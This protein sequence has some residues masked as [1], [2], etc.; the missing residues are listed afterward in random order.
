M[1]ILSLRFKNLNSLA[2]E[3][4]LD[5]ENGPLG[6][7]GIFL[8]SGPTGAGKTT[9]LDAI[10]VALYE[11][12]PRLE[13]SGVRNIMTQQKGDCF[14]EV[15][16]NVKDKIYRSRWTLRRAYGKATGNF[17]DSERELSVLEDG[18]FVIL[19]NKKKLI[20][21]KTADITGLNFD[22]FTRSMLLPQGNFAAFLEAKENERAD[23]LEKMTGTTIYSEISQE[24]YKIY[25]EEQQK[26][27]GLKAQLEDI[28]PSTEE[29]LVILR[30]NKKNTEEGIG[31]VTKEISSLQDKA[32]WLKTIEILKIDIERTIKSLNIVEEKAKEKNNDFYKLEKAQKAQV[33]KSDYDKIA[34]MK[35]LITKK[36]EH[37]EDLKRKK[38]GL[39]EESKRL[40]SEF[41]S[42]TTS[43]KSFKKLKEEK[44]AAI[45]K[46][47]VKDSEIK[48]TKES[49]SNI[50]KNEERKKLLLKEL[51]KDLEINKNNFQRV[52]NEIKESSD[53]LE[54]IQSFA[55]IETT[56]FFLKEKVKVLDAKSI[57]LSKAKEDNQ[58][59]V[60]TLA[61]SKGDIESKEKDL[62]EISSSIESFENELK[63]ISKNIESHSKSDSDP[64]KDLEKHM[65]SISFFESL[66]KTETEIEELIKEK[67]NITETLTKNTS[68]L[69]DYESKREKIKN[70]IT[71]TENTIKEFEDK[72][73]QEL[74]ISK[75]EDDRAKLI[76]ND[77]CPLC[78][79]K[80]HPFKSITTNENQTET[81]LIDYKEKLSSQYKNKDS[82]SEKIIKLMTQNEHL[83]R[84]LSVCDNN[85]IKQNDIKSELI[86][87][88]AEP[89]SQDI[90]ELKQ[91]LDLKIDAKNELEREI[92]E[93]KLLNEKSSVIKDKISKEEKIK[94]EKRLALQKS[95]DNIVLL[96]TEKKIL[97]KSIKEYND[98]IDQI[99]TEISEIADKFKATYEKGD[100][101]KLIDYLQLKDKEYK[102]LKENLSKLENSSSVLK[103]KVSI[104]KNDQNNI[105]RDLKEIDENLKSFDEKLESL[106]TKRNEILKEKNIIL[107]KKDLQRKN[108][109]YKDNILMLEKRENSVKTELKVVTEKQKAIDDELVQ[110]NSDLKALTSEFLENIKLSG[111][112]SEADLAKDLMDENDK[113]EL[114]K[115]RKEIDD[116]LLREK[117]RID[118]LTKKLNLKIEEKK[119][120][121][122]IA[123]IEGELNTASLKQDNLK[124]ELWE[125]NNKLK[126]DTELRQKK[127]K[128]ID[129]IEL[130][131][132]EFSKWSQ[133]NELIGS[134]DGKKFRRYA[135]GLTLEYLINL[136]NKHLVKLNNR[137]FMKRKE[138]EDLG[139][140]I[141]DDFKAQLSRPV[142]TLSG[143]ESFLVSL[144]LALGLS[145]LVSRNVRIDSIFLDEGFGSL[146]K[147][148]MEVAL[149]ALDN[150]NA[151]GKTIGIISHIDSLKERISV[152]LRVDRKSHGEST[153]SYAL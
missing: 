33:F 78:G 123:D 65:K 73:K 76:E 35:K 81:I 86:K 9:I 59:I 139:I 10:C 8:I 37:S 133:L 13:G 63:E 67:F 58:K 96:E 88:N 121:A 6:E 24:T 140:D 130:Q 54:E 129:K 7:A 50:A 103:D 120:D 57:S 47:I 12:T 53:V 113:R 29:E 153:L 46:A 124:K 131:R 87:T 106:K 148:S 85:S 52:G 82:E 105:E 23:L 84:N 83:N 147:D 97:I 2:D 27:N 34:Q 21:K 5:F 101:N 71:N 111:F 68:F 132:K 95:R 60:T 14:S 112:E 93:L 3:F 152:Q 51:T 92:K 117:T 66:I 109:L 62:I 55:N 141:V 144:S 94:G 18:N 99:S 136:A 36:E 72:L 42:E 15:E 114:E 145:S 4:H 56:L 43:Y 138:G 28:L 135:Q 91:S 122:D 77:P 116:G 137:Y 32:D 100:E 69:K 64:E 128:Q 146:D 31:V 134:F 26:F 104:Q 151:T 107:L 40:K 39:S 11:R 108:Q 25:K 38:P 19:E 125:I 102:S 110:I 79:S 98:N 150:L 80:D 89:F 126:I 30:E 44:I 22:R 149:D 118:D 16:F 20:N 1:K 119:T 45:E 17:Q 127:Q 142:K 41:E 49:I 48:S 74:L 143:G 90:S 75:Y 115:L 70:D 61:R